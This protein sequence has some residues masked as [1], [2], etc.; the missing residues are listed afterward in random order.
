[1]SS[2]RELLAPYL[3]ERGLYV[4][5]FT[6]R[7]DRFHL[8]RFFR[9]LDRQGVSHVGTVDLETLGAYQRYLETVPGE[10]GKLASEA[11]LYKSLSLPKAF[12]RWALRRGLTLNDV[13]SFPLPHRTHPEPKIPTVEQVKK[14]L[15]AT[16]TGS[17][18]GKRDSLILESFYT[19]GLR[20]RESHQLDLVD[21]NLAKQ[22]LRVRG[23]N[24]R[25]R[26][27]PVSDRLCGL[28]SD[29]LKKGRP[30]LRPCPDEEALWVSQCNGT[31]LCYESLRNTV[32]RAAKRVGVSGVYPHL[33]RHACATHLLEAGAKLSVI[34]AFL[35]HNSPDSTE[36]YTHVSQQELQTVFG[37]CHPR[38]GV[39]EPS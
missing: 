24:Q 37:R 35:G 11:Y 2:P 14:L 33:L 10:R 7:D 30:Y 3:E 27:L 28:F 23:K 13:E 22:T 6:V 19:L 16:H 5:A 9:F 15:D 20:R 8:M 39:E 26:L 29:Y 1:M 17:P 31:R 21:L 34:Q 12:L 18:Q 36:R 32:L 38:A 4:S 25:E